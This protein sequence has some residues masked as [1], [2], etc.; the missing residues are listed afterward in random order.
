MKKL[1]LF[2][3]FLLL[4]TSCVPKVALS[5][6]YWQ[7]PTKVGILINDNPPAKFKEGSQGLLDMAVTSGDKY[8]EALNLIGKNIHPKEELTNIYSEIFKS[9]GKEIIIIDEKF[10]HKTAK[11]FSGEKAEGKKYSSYDFSDLKAKYGV[12]EILFVNAN[13]G[14]MISYY[15]MIETGKMAHAAIDTKIID[16]NDQHLIMANQNFKNEVLKKW[17]DNNYENSIKGVRTA[18]DKAESEEKAIFDPK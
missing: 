8:Q 18:L 14:F 11:K 7:K 3:S 2:F 5:A 15:G 1:I 9:K 10:D 6:E 17:K 16:L 12:D 13:Y 4:V